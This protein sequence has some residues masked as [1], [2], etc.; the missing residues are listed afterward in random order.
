M[1][2]YPVNVKLLSGAISPLSYSAL[3]VSGAVHVA[4]AAFQLNEIVYVIGV[5]CAVKVTVS[6]S[7]VVKLLTF[8]LSVYHVVQYIHPLNSYQVFVKALRFKVHVIS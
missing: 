5:H 7:V 1:K 6:P 4:S 3:I 2:V 8:C